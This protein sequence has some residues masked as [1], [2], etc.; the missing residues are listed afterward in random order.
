MTEILP[1]LLDR[2][3]IHERLRDIFPEGTP[4]RG[5]CTREIAASTIFTMLY[6]GAIEDRECYLA[7]KHV[8]RMS[9]AQ[10]E[11]QSDASRIEYAQS[12]IR[13]GFTSLGKSWYADTTR[14]PIR[15][16]TLRQ[17]LISVGAAFERNLPP[18]SPKGRYRLRRDFVALFEPAMSPNELGNAVEEWQNL[19]LN[20]AALSRIE[21]IRSG[22]SP[23][24][25]DYLVTFPNGE[26]QRLSPG[27][28][29]VIT[30]AVVERFAPRYLEEPHVIWVSESGNKVVARNDLQAKKL[31]L[32][33]DTE[34]LLPDII[35][36]D[37]AEMTI[38]FVEVVS[39][40][41]PIH[42]RRRADLLDLA[43]GGG[44][45]D[46]SIAF[47]TAFISRGPALKR[48]IADLAWN[49]FVWIASEPDCLIKLRKD[50][51]TERKWLHHRLT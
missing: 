14:E 28:S 17:G 18:T 1:P 47:V 32:N 40:D 5:Y 15:D 51:G 41:G 30:K 36:V 45:K 31:G 33:L 29:S 25:E 48:A 8:Y 13:P 4:H 19:H 37:L 49:T 44:H 6:I 10:A 12:A 26:T 50:E 22:A 46:E 35:L 34:R 42:S 23:D 9:E 11:K 3:Q 24:P 43:R 21:L 27:E 38:V 7:P 20:S 2:T 16:E 39:S